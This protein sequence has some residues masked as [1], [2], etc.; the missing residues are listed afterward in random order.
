MSILP[1]RLCGAGGIAAVSII[2]TALPGFA[3]QGSGEPEIIEVH[4]KRIT[5]PA[6]TT[7]NPDQ[8]NFPAA[9]DGGDFLDA[10]TGI[11][12]RRMSGF[13]LEPVIRGQQQN[14]INI[15][16]DGAIQHGGGPNRMDPP[17]SY[18]AVETYDSVTVIRGFQTVLYAPGGPGGTVIFERSTPRFSKSEG[19]RARAGSGY[20]SNGDVRN[21]YGDVAVGTPQFF[22]R[23]IFSW[24]KSD[25][26]KDGNGRPVRSGF[27]TR[28]MGA[29]VGYTPNDDTR[30]SLGYNHDR[31][32][33]VL[34]AGAGLDSPLT[35][36]DTWRLKASRQVDGDVVQKLRFEGYVADLAHNMD[37]FT[38]RPP[39]MIRAR[40]ATTSNTFGGRFLADLL[41]AGA[42]L[43]LGADVQDNERKA[44]RF[45]VLP[46]GMEMLQAVLWP[47]VTI[48]HIGLFGEGGLS[49]GGADRLRYGLRYDIVRST[50]KQ[51][52]EVVMMTGQ[53]ANDH[54]LATYGV[55]AGNDTD[56]NLSGFVRYE[57]DLSPA[58]TASLGLGRAVRSPDATERFIDNV[59]PM[60]IWIGNPAL[61]PEKHTQAEAGLLSRGTDWYVYASLFADWVS[62]YIHRDTARGQAGILRADGATVY[63]NIKAFLGGGELEAHVRFAKRWMAVASLAYV[64]GQNRADHIA[65]PQIPPLNG[66]LMLAYEAKRFSLGGRMEWA[67]KQTRVDA[68]SATGSGRDIR[69]TPGYGVFDV[70][71]SVKLIEAV[72]LRIGLSNLFDKT[73]AHHINRANLVD[74]LEVQVNEPGRSVYLR[75]AASL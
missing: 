17:T 45:M 62:D 53:S 72:E 41:L 2:A 11:S 10:V 13:A 39:G 8:W 16:N 38:L 27:E 55:S 31:H 70:F 57:H 46:T 28:S 69:Q 65:L 9:R 3:A 6:I 12:A 56:H 74:P 51:A 14:Q 42:K 40:V 54:Y 58:T 29:T 33:N 20:D 63:R 68:N 26:Y 4:G 75:L 15:I 67:L 52:G 23:G 47:D 1:R 37:N 59:G 60:G 73:Y 32:T 5:S 7:I 25:N 64:Y 71:G 18:A 22:A 24:M 43:T 35:T 21:A 49:L 50:V 61:A 44:R 19:P 34:F 30:I 48:R 36:G 66:S